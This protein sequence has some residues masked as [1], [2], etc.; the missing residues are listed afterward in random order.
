[1]NTLYITETEEG[2]E[3]IGEDGLH[4]GI[5]ETMGEAITSA[6]QHVELGNYTS[7]CIAD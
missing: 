6:K 4:Q 7:F 3:L 2:F 5:A 1:M